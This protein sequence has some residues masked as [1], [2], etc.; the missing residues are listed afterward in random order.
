MISLC[1]IFPIRSKIPH[2]ALKRGSEELG[3]VLYQ[4]NGD[5]I[6]SVYNPHLSYSRRQSNIKER[7]CSFVTIFIR[8]TEPSLTHRNSR[9][10][11]RYSNSCPYQEEFEGSRL[12]KMISLPNPS[13]PSAYSSTFRLRPSMICD[14]HYQPQTMSDNFTER[15][16]EVN[17]T[18]IV[19]LQLYNGASWI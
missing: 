13:K 4:V 2:I 15:F 7:R 10:V 8:E 3:Q 11:G 19:L 14:H 6:L 5:K 1:F 16:K 9:E 12:R 18:R 17:Y